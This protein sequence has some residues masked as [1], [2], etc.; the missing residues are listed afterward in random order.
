MSTSVKIPPKIE[1]SICWF[2]PHMRIKPHCS[3]E[4]IRSICQRPLYVLHLNFINN[5]KLDPDAN[6]TPA[7]PACDMGSNLCVACLVDGDC[8]D[9]DWCTGVETCSAGT[10]NAGTLQCTTLPNNVC[11]GILEQC[12]ECLGSGDCADTPA[13]PMC[14]VGTGVCEECLVDGDCTD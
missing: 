7:T 2:K 1:P 4:N 10:C 13:T 5:K 14:N 11:D 9:S 6:A 12:V 3:Q 8:D